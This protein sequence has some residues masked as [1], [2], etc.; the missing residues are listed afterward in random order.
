M[1]LNAVCQEVV[2]GKLSFWGQ[3]PG[4]LSWS[5]RNLLSLMISLLG[6]IVALSL[7][8]GLS[9]SR[10]QNGRAPGWGSRLSLQLLVSAQVIVSG[11]QDWTPCWAPHSAGRLLVSLPSAP[12]PTLVQ[13]LS[14]KYINLKKKKKNS[15]WL[16]VKQKRFLE[17]PIQTR[18]PVVESWLV[19]ASPLCSLASET[20]RHQ[21]WMCGTAAAKPTRSHSAWR[22]L[23]GPDIYQNT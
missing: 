6:A 2:P 10:I 13:V 9:F 1:L 12:P 23:K 17:G 18:I 19:I 14:L 22:L 15:K 5:I 11:S 16:K 8:C 21:P 3:L 4:D 7:F 20:P